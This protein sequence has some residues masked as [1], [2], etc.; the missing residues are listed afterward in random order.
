IYYAKV[1]KGAYLN[2]KKIQPSN[3]KSLKKLTFCCSIKKD[4]K[5][6]QRLLGEDGSYKMFGSWAIHFAYVAAGKFDLCFCN[7]KDVHGTAAGIIIAQEAGCFIVDE[8]LNTWNLGSKKIVISCTKDIY[9]TIK[10]D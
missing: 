6:F 2:G 1:G 7:I 9:I 4:F 3:Q 8:K 10:N 5:A